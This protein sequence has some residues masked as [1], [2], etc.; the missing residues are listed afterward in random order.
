MTPTLSPPNPSTAYITFDLNLA[1]WLIAEAKL[2][3]CGAHPRRDNSKSMCFLFDDT[4]Q[5]GLAM[6]E[7]FNFGRASVN[8]KTFV[9]AKEMLIKLVQDNR[10]GGCDANSPR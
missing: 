7:E 2:R 10:R 5:L 3:F 8:V 9:I 6:Q 1:A 4:D